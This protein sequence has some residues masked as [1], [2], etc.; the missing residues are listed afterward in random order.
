MNN[1]W[2]NQLDHLIQ[3]N[4][5]SF[6]LATIVNH[7][8]KTS[9]LHFFDFFKS[10]L[11]RLSSLL[12]FTTSNLIDILGV[13]FKHEN[14][15]QLSIHFFNS[16][17]L[18]RLTGKLI[19]VSKSHSN[20]PVWAKGVDWFHLRNALNPSNDDSLSLILFDADKVEIYDGDQLQ[21]MEIDVPFMSHGRS[22]GT[23]WVAV[24]SS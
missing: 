13:S 24:G 20:V 15:A 10:N 21:V 23:K 5:C 12:I 19:Y 18:F 8:P 17:Y 6:T 16:K 2:Q 22:V 4:S 11:P 3:T 7:R 1:N 9:S 14:Y